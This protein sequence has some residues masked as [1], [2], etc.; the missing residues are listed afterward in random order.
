[1]SQVSR[2]QSQIFILKDL[3]ESLNQK[4]TEHVSFDLSEH[5][6]EILTLDNYCAPVDDQN[7][8][9]LLGKFCS[10]QLSK[11]S[12]EQLDNEKFFQAISYQLFSSTNSLLVHSPSDF[13]AKLASMLGSIESI[14]D[15]LTKTTSIAQIKFES[16][17]SFLLSTFY[18]YIH[19][20]NHFK[21]QKQ[22]SQKISLSQQCHRPEAK[23]SAHLI[24]ASSLFESKIS[25]LNEEKN[26]Q[27]L[28]KL[29]KFLIYLIKNFKDAKSNVFIWKMI[30]KLCVK[31]KILLNDYTNS[32]D[33]LQINGKFL[34]KN[35][36]ILIY[37]D[38][39]LNLNY[40]KDSLNRLSMN[41]ADRVSDM[42]SAIGSQMTL[43]NNIYLD[44]AKVVKLSAFLA[45][46]LKSFLGLYFDDLFNFL[47]NEF[48]NMLTNL[49]SSVNSI[50][51]TESRINSQCLTIDQND[52]KS[53]QFVNFPKE[54]LSIKL[55]FIKEFSPIYESFLQLIGT[56]THYAN[57]MYHKDFFPI[58]KT[59][60]PDEFFL[61]NSQIDCANNQQ[62]YNDDNLIF[63]LIFINRTKIKIDDQSEIKLSFDQV[64]NPAYLNQ[65]FNLVEFSSLSVS[66][67]TYFLYNDHFMQ[68]LDFN[69]LSSINYEAKIFSRIEFYDFVLICLSRYILL[70]TNSNSNLEQLVYFLVNNLLIVN[71]L[72]DENCQ[73][74]NNIYQLYPLRI[75]LSADLLTNLSK[76]LMKS[77][78]NENFLNFI[79]FLS[80]IY[81]T[82]GSNMVFNQNIN[83]QFVLKQILE[84]CYLSNAKFST[85]LSTLKDF[86]IKKRLSNC[87]NLILPYLN[88][89]TDTKK[90]IFRVNVMEKAIDLFDALIKLFLEKNKIPSEQ[91]WM[92]KCIVFLD[93]NH[94]CEILSIICGFYDP[95]KSDDSTSTMTHDLVDKLLKTITK[96]LKLNEIVNIGKYFDHFG[97]YKAEISRK[98]EK[99]TNNFNN[100]Q[101]SL[102]FENFKR[103]FQFI[104]VCSRVFAFLCLK[105]YLKSSSS[106][107]FLFLLD[108][109]ISNCSQNYETK[110]GGMVESAFLNI[111][112]EAGQFL[113]NLSNREINDNNVMSKILE[114]FGIL[115]N[116]SSTLVKFF[117]LESLDEYSKANESNNKIICQLSRSG[118]N[119]NDLI[120]NY[121]VEISID[122]SFDEMSYYLEKRNE[123]IKR[124][125][126]CQ[127]DKEDILL[128]QKIED[129]HGLDETMNAIMCAMDTT[130][131]NQES[132]SNDAIDE[133]DSAQ[134]KVQSILNVI[135]SEL[136]KLSVICDQQ[137]MSENVKIQLNSLASRISSLI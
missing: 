56:N 114:L 70:S 60:E 50:L 4:Q 14:Y 118:K 36:F 63:F 127:Q 72:I 32:I 121:L 77:D 7:T 112:L 47:Q 136:D 94:F 27:N 54:Y 110:I 23:L 108:F 38:Q 13:E 48:F 5:D 19:L 33:F 18:L 90:D 42:S 105:S 45:K 101:L 26:K 10:N 37:E 57:Y 46:I 130:I 104:C 51:L 102:N 8:I 109:F 55:D 9:E 107:D 88:K 86:Y 84:S 15:Y 111:K 95:N 99:N 44:T 40:I 98:M 103:I 22:S 65:I 17:D 69:Y 24:K 137:S 43:K 119:V 34:I 116:D 61:Q 123:L 52:F 11:L 97:Q 92:K 41:E 132:N 79:K 16:I 25:K 68:H 31:F 78:G 125:K 124:L 58:K 106:E 89:S 6:L 82:N 87:F 1:M 3:V 29:T 83:L 30:S 2:N 74:Q 85:L 96:F 75:Q 131:S 21:N 20:C 71:N 49:L 115:L 133:D 66:L 100:K 80:E 117:T 53:S 28:I 126:I 128:S 35:I 134:S 39:N 91:I 135:S 12:F 64:K 81:E 113:R 120:L 93:S 67:P 59:D 62:D 122:N 129:C 76:W 73:N